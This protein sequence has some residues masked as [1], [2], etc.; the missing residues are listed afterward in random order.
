[1]TPGLPKT[2]RDLNGCS[3][4][5]ILLALG[6]LGLILL[7]VVL[8]QV[9]RMMLSARC[10]RVAAWC[11][12]FSSVFWWGQRGEFGLLEVFKSYFSSR[13][14]HS[15]SLSNS[16]GVSSHA[17]CTGLALPSASACSLAAFTHGSCSAPSSAVV[18]LC[19]CMLMTHVHVLIRGRTRLVH[20]VPGGERVS[21]VGFPVRRK[22]CSLSQR[23]RLG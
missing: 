15:K 2:S 5:A 7:E 9:A 16:S 8:W 1:M 21:K 23:W 4:F 11:C 14:A 3:A 20:R 13:L 10:P 6:S 22:I 18:P 19:I 17:G 12:V